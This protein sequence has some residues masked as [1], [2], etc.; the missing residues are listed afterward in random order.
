MS[1]Q[2]LLHDEGEESDQPAGVLEYRAR[3]DPLKLLPS[4]ERAGIGIGRLL[5]SRGGIHWNS[6]ITRSI[7]TPFYVLGPFSREADVVSS[8]DFG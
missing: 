4:R 8:S 5:R 2:R 1:R 7:D 3:D 6:T